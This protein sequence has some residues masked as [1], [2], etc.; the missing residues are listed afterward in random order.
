MFSLLKSFSVYMLANTNTSALSYCFLMLSSFTPQLLSRS[1]IFFHLLVLFSWSSWCVFCVF[2]FLPALRHNWRWA[3]VASVPP[4]C[5]FT[6]YVT[7]C[8][9]GRHEVQA[10]NLPEDA[11]K[12][13]PASLSARGSGSCAQCDTDKLYLM[14]ASVFGFDLRIYYS[15][16]NS[17]GFCLHIWIYLFIFPLVLVHWLIY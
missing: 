10:T 17:R 8:L 1:F 5:P 16:I 9:I 4:M 2:L 3:N 12:F 7:L 14:F 6:Q 11:R 13:S 15:W